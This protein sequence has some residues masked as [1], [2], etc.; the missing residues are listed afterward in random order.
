V[1]DFATGEVGVKSEP[2]GD[3]EDEEDDDM[4]EVDVDGAQSADPKSPDLPEQIP[5]AASTTRQPSVPVEG[6]SSVRLSR[7]SAR[8]AKSRLAVDNP[9][10]SSDED[11]EKGVVSDASIHEVD[12]LAA[13]GDEDDD[14]GD[15]MAE[16]DF[17][18]KEPTPPPAAPQTTRSGRTIKLRIGPVKEAEPE[19]EGEKSASSRV[20]RSSK[21]KR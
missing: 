4:E 10:E 15:S 11:D 2:A 17:T 1:Q 18:P 5:S 3:S 8:E 12:D 7:R 16:V 6:A 9:Y 20:T 14:S 19:A 21:R 13:G